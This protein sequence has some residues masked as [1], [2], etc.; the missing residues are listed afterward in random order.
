MYL[1]KLFASIFL[2]EPLTKK[3]IPCETGRMTIMGCPEGIP[4]ETG[5]MAI[6]GCPEGIPCETGCM[7]IMG[8]PEDILGCP[9][10]YKI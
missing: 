2:F 8:C 7:A 5:R 4:C 1:H 6:M 3:I 10:G 9:K